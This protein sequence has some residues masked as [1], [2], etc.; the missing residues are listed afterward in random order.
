MFFIVLLVEFIYSLDFFHINN[1]GI[2]DNDCGNEIFPCG[3]FE[4]IFETRTLN[5][6]E[7]AVLI[8]DGYVLNTLG[9]NGIKEGGIYISQPGKYYLYGKGYSDN[10]YSTVN[11]PSGLGHIRCERDVDILLLN[12][13]SE[14]GIFH[15]Y[16]TD[17]EHALIY[18]NISDVIVNITNCIFTT[19]PNYDM[20]TALSPSKI[21]RIFNGSTL[22]M[23]EVTISNFRISFDRVDDKQNSTSPIVIGT[24]DNSKTHGILNKLNIYNM[25]LPTNDLE[26]GIFTGNNAIIEFNSCIFNNIGGDYNSLFR[27]YFLSFYFLLCLLFFS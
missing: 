7:K 19:G 15:W 3:D 1:T 18:S 13:V 4:Y 16:S 20:N 17:G 6:N 27:R 2:N 11:I 22:I 8:P 26:F 5:E 24:G 9:S 10:I 14:N 21:I 23:N 12:F 25:K